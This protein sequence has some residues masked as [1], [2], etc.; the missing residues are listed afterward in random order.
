MEISS[1]PANNFVK[2]WIF[3]VDVASSFSWQLGCLA[4]WVG[5]WHQWAQGLLFPSQSLCPQRILHVPAPL[6]L[7]SCPSVQRNIWHG[8]GL[9]EVA[10]NNRK[11]IWDW[12]LALPLSVCLWSENI[13]PPGALV[14]PSGK[15]RYQHSEF[16]QSSLYK[17]NEVSLWIC[18]KLRTDSRMTSC[19]SL[20][21]SEGLLWAQDFQ[22]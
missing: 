13:G 18:W 19:P 15:W 5:A 22:C 16:H 3:H 8:T 11:Q 20:S 12:I 10:P 4:Y 14:L 1:E 21:E 17:S 2:S 7:L 6:P 9:W